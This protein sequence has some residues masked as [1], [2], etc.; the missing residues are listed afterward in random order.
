M[1]TKP[2]RFDLSNCYH[3][4]NCGVEKRDTFT[5]PRDYQRC[6]QTIYYYLYDQRFS[7]AQFQELSLEGQQLYSQT[8]PR[9]PDKL[10]VKLLAYCLM[11]NHFHFLLKPVRLD[12]I[13]LFIADISNSHTRYFNV[14]NQRIGSLFQ[15]TYKAKEVSNISSLLQV[16]RYIHLNPQDPQDL[17]VKLEDY[18]FS[19]YKE[20]LN[21]QEPALIDQEEV[22]FYLDSLRDIPSYRD[23]VEAGLKQDPRLGIEDLVLD[24]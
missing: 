2:R 10:R 9:N 18:P 1:T 8:H 12:G 7:F 14:K 6:L 17:G 11:P 20:W 3:V 5:T 23:F 24:P 15:G 22:N 21:P 16:S 13:T 19:S 4:Y